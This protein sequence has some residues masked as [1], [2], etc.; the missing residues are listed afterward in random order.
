MH[1]EAQQIPMNFTV[2]LL[3]LNLSKLICHNSSVFAAVCFE[4]PFRDEL[5]NDM[6]YDTLNSHDV[7]VDF[8][9]V[10]VK[11]L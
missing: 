6:I 10:M 9:V 5:V 7:T 4:Q 3:G 2:V 1:I 11:R 8:N